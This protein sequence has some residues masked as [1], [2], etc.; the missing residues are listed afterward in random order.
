MIKTFK[1][2]EAERVF[3]RRRS[4]RLPEDIQRRAFT[5]LLLLDQARELRD[6]ASPP[7]NRLEAL[8]GDRQGQHAIRINRQWRVCFVWEGGHAYDVEVVDYH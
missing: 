3:L 1:D 4:R 6:L 7:A 5:K 8:R 2:K